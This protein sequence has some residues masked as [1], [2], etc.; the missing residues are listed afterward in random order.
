MSVEILARLQCAVTIA[1]LYIIH[2]KVK[3]DKMSHGVRLGRGRPGPR[4]LKSSFLPA[5]SVSP[6]VYELPPGRN[7][8]GFGLWRTKC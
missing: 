1:F 6:A 8:F 4:Q 7:P 5:P 2:G 3:L